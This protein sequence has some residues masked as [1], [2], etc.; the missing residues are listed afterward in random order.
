MVLGGYGTDGGVNG[1]GEPANSWAIGEALARTAASG[2]GA[3]L[4]ERFDEAIA[5]VVALEVDHVTLPLEWAALQAVH[6]EPGFAEL[7]R[8]LAALRAAGIGVEVRLTDSTTPAS[9]G[10]EFWLRPDA[11]TRF[12]QFASAVVDRIGSSIDRITTVHDPVRAVVSGYLLGSRPPFRRLAIA[13]AATALDHLLAGHLLA[14]DAVVASSA[15]IE[16]AIGLS[17]LAAPLAER[18][19]GALGH[20]SAPDSAGIASAADPLGLDGDTWLARQHG[21]TFARTLAEGGT[22]GTVVDVVA[23]STPLRVAVGSRSWT[24]AGRSRGD[25]LPSLG[26]RVAPL[27][28]IVESTP[29]RVVRGLGVP[30]GE[31]NALVD[32]LAVRAEQLARVE[33]SVRYTYDG[34]LDG[35]RDGSFEWCS[36]IVHVDRARGSAGGRWS[37]CDVGGANAS[38]ALRELGRRVRAGEA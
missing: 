2:I 5:R 37:D 13:D 15:S 18:L 3:N 32:H 25:D 22:R 19:A 29:R 21:R 24:S 20:S 30:R 8:R 17:T 38:T 26:V 33:G 28:S 7:E 1:P 4:S 16:V 14:A 34:L 10:Q 27:V 12:A 36:G 11:P 6:A 35:L 23:D 9:F 31:P